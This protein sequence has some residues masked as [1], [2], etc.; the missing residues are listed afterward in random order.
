M[1]RGGFLMRPRLFRR[2]RK[3]ATSASGYADAR[4]A[5]SSRA[6]PTTSCPYDSC[7]HRHPELPPPWVKS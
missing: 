4:H 2:W 3:G 5:G 6:K 1:T 7:H